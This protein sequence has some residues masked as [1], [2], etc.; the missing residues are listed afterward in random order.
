MGDELDIACLERRVKRNP[1][2]F[3]LPVFMLLLIVLSELKHIMYV[4]NS[5]VC[6]LHIPPSWAFP[7]GSET[8]PELFQQART[9]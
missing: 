5:V 8:D 4:S 7:A 3:I 6:E 9:R 2:Q 1:A